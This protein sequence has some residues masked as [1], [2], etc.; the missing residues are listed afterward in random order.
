MTTISVSCA[1]SDKLPGVA[2]LNFEAHG[3]PSSGAAEGRVEDVCGDRAQEASP[4][5][6]SEAA[7]FSNRRRVIFACSPAAILNS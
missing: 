6:V 4:C 2:I 5:S 3:D 7:S 1:G